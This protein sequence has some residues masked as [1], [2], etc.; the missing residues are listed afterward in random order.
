MGAIGM[1]QYGADGLADSGGKYD[2][3]LAHYYKG[4]KLRKYT[5]KERDE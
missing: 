4:A 5:L 2:Q 3:I 1:C